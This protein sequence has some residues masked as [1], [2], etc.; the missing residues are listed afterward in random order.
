ML[1]SLAV[2]SHVD[3]A[4]SHTCVHCTHRAHIHTHTIKTRVAWRKMGGKNPTTMSNELLLMGTL[5][6]RPHAHRTA[7]TCALSSWTH[8][9]MGWPRGLDLAS[10]LLST[11]LSSPTPVA[12]FKRAARRPPPLL[13]SVFQHECRRP[14]RPLPPPAP[15]PPK[16]LDTR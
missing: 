11:T 1:F 4:P 14:P 7:D 6:P 16:L 3:S 8:Y 5:T 10:P 13:V 15:P 2:L 12:N 9:H